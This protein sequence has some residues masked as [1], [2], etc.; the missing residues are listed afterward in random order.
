MNLHKKH[1]YIIGAVVLVLVV[2]FL[3][4][5]EHWSSKIVSGR[6]VSEASIVDRTDDTIVVRLY[7]M[8]ADNNK[9]ETETFLTLQGDVPSDT[10]LGQD[11]RIGYSYDGLYEDTSQS[12]QIAYYQKGNL[13]SALILPRIPI[14]GWSDA[15]TD[16]RIVDIQSDGTLLSYN[17]AR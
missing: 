11:V 3:I 14:L 2:S 1:W 15:G 6:Y 8:T 12:V 10:Y 7:N 16:L 9:I 5:T 17:R 13:F 4:P